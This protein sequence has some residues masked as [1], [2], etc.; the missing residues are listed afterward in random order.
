MNYR[1]KYLKYKAKYLNLQKGGEFDIETVTHKR[2]RREISSFLG[3]NGYI[4]DLTYN[5]KKVNDLDIITIEIPSKKIKITIQGLYPFI[6]KLTLKLNGITYY[7]EN[8]NVMTNMGKFIKDVIN[9]DVEKYSNLVI[10]ILIAVPTIGKSEHVFILQSDNI[11]DLI[12][13]IFIKFTLDK[14]KNFVSHIKWEDNKLFYFFK[15]NANEKILDILPKNKELRF[16]VQLSKFLTRDFLI[17]TMK[18]KSEGPS[19]IIDENKNTISKSK[20]VST[21]ETSDLLDSIAYNIYLNK[22]YIESDL[23]DIFRTKE[24]KLIFNDIGVNPVVFYIK[25]YLDEFAEKLKT[26]PYFDKIENISEYLLQIITQH[27]KQEDNFN[28]TLIILLFGDNEPGRNMYP[29]FKLNEDIMK[30]YDEYI[31]NTSNIIELN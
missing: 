1:E 8:W 30:V 10:P 11:T 15:N 19:F 24:V 4:L 9:N 23:L 22:D 14:N 20:I 7:T 12:D 17:E 16:K 6:H 3:E 26:I 27:I 25:S 13:K 5:E 2:L 21:F 31:N 28:F 18:D 29:D